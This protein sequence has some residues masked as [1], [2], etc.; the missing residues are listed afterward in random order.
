M[1]TF[2]EQPL[3]SSLNSK[4]VAAPFN[5]HQVVVTAQ[6]L[7][8]SLIYPSNIVTIR[9][10]LVSLMPISVFFNL[11]IASPDTE[12]H[13]SKYLL[14]YRRDRSWVV[15]SLE[16]LVPDFC[17]SKGWGNKHCCEIL[18]DGPNGSNAFVLFRGIWIWIKSNLKSANH[19]TCWHQTCCQCKEPLFKMCL[20]PVFVPANT[21]RVWI[22]DCGCSCLSITADCL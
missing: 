10:S 8:R 6:N 15:H 5:H 12:I 20:C 13:C 22:S 21:H 4:M 14:P 18:V 11:Y 9:V 1:E 16:N 19:M 17:A 2:Q 7:M 3:V